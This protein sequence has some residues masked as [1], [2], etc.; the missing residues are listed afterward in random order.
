M[1]ASQTATGG[2]DRIYDAIEA[3]MP[4]V[5]HPVV[6]L[7]VWDALEEFCSRST[8]WR[9]LLNWEMAIG[10]TQLDLN[11]VDTNIRVHWVL[12]VCGLG[13]CFRI[14]PTSILVDTS[15]GVH[16][17]GD[18]VRSGTAWVV[19]KPS[20]LSAEMPAWVDDWS[21][22]LRDGALYRLYM[23]PAKP[24][25]SLPMAQFHGKRFRTQIQLARVE[26]KKLCEGDAPRFPYFA[27]GRLFQGFGCA[28]PCS[29]TGTDG[30]ITPP[31]GVVPVLA[32]SPGVLSDIVTPPAPGPA[33]TIGEGVITDTTGPGATLGAGS[34]TFGATTVGGTT[35]PQNVV[36][37]NTGDADLI[38]TAVTPT[39][40]FAVTGVT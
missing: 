38:I 30:A 40:D 20:R 25:S 34:L 1:S 17:P 32:I 2:L 6:Q 10:E 15:S 23:Q 35:V 36:V 4:G 37:T 39:G 24:Y 8:Y 22:G 21:E 7:V 29:G 14:K 13:S 16:T 5:L 9:E 3:V 19:C 31:V 33:L 18:T 27:R 12:N 26:A 28:G 11:P